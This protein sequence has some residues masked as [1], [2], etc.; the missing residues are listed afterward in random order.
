MSWRSDSRADTPSE[1]NVSHEGTKSR[2]GLRRRKALRGFIPSCLICSDFR[3]AFRTSL[4]R[5]AQVISADRAEADRCS[6]MLTKEHVSAAKWQHDERHNQYPMRQ[7][8]QSAPILQLRKF[9]TIL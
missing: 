6:A 9:G 1:K 5:G 8:Q 4:R 7:D 3:A 2:S